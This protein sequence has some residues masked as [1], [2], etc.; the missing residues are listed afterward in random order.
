MLRQPCGAA[1]V[2]LF[3]LVLVHVPARG[4]ENLGKP[5][6]F[7]SVH[8]PSLFFRDAV[9]FAGC[10]PRPRANVNALDSTQ[11]RSVCRDHAIHAAASF[12]RA[13]CVDGESEAE[14]DMSLGHA[15]FPARRPACAAA[16][17]ARGH[18]AHTW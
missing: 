16:A 7:H 12:A 14:A 6:S 11:R 17:A 3:T 5:T 8:Q 15:C 9:A 2:S 18:D 4:D 1:G 10:D 13:R